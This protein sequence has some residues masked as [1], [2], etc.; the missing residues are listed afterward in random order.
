KGYFPYKHRNVRGAYASL[1][2]CMKYLFT[3]EEYAHLNI[4]KTT[5]RLK[6]LFK[7]L[8][9]KLSVHKGLTRKYNIMFIKVF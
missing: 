5:N 8:R 3:F 9:Q 4:E 1:K 7:D 6:G 2:Y